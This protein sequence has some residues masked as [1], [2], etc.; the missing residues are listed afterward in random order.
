MEE[1]M[2]FMN[3]KIF[4]LN[5]MP[6]SGKD[7]FVNILKT[8][9]S[10]QKISWVDPALDVIKKS[11]IDISEKTAADRVLISDIMDS[12][13]RYDSRCFKYVVAKAAE[14]MHDEKTEALFIDIRAKCN[15]CKT[16]IA[17]NAQSILIVPEH[18]FVVKSPCHDDSPDNFHADDHDY[19]IRNP[20]TIP[21]FK[22]VINEFWNSVK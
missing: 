22:E 13:E 14:F 9:A 15:R 18:D 4:I 12:L 6:H 1:R 5:G 17:L 11:G 19:I 16:G 21:A 7:T 2:V 3:K 20:G 8:F 10:V